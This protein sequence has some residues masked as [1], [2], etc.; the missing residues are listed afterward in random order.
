MDCSR[1]LERCVKA[2]ATEHGA[3]ARSCALAGSR[4]AGGVSRAGDQGRRWSV[5]IAMAVLLSIGFSPRLA[6]AQQVTATPLM[7][8]DLAD[9]PGKEGVV[10]AV[11]Y[12]PGASEPAHRHNAYVFVYVVEGAVVMQVQGRKEV[13]LSVGQTFYEAPSDVHVVGRNASKTN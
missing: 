7:A 9:F 13:T 1:P 6:I 12:A 5:R 2:L 10:L 11:E 3:L 8:E 4:G